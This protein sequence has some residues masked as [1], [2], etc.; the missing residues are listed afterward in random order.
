MLP[1]YNTHLC[2]PSNTS[3]V[4]NVYLEDGNCPE[5]CVLNETLDFCTYPSYTVQ[6]CGVFGDQQTCES[7]GC[8]WIVPNTCVATCTTPPVQS[9]TQSTTPS[10]QPTTSTPP[11][12]STTQSVHST[13]ST[14]PA[15]S[16][17]Q[18][19]VPSTTEVIR[20]VP[21]ETSTEKHD[22]FRI[23]SFV[24]LACAIVVLA[25]AALVWFYKINSP[26]TITFIKRIFS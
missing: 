20:D 10:V 19:T 16:G 8:V 6:I 7:L 14:P 22:T 24:A 13:T 11:T 23:A 9:T 1:V 3:L 4:C 18:T 17:T 25:A 12:Q 5:G 21:Y 15:Q 26:R 2:A